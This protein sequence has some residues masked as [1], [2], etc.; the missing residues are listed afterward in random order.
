MARRIVVA[1]L[2]GGVGKSTTVLNLGQALS[3]L[4]HRVLLIDL[5]PQAG[6]TASVGID[7]YDLQRSTYSLLMKD[8]IA[9]GRVVKQLRDRL[10]LVPATEN[11]TTAEIKLARQSK[12]PDRLKL[13]LDH[14]PV[15]FDY[16]LIDTPPTL[17]TLTLNGLLA[18]NELIIPV[19][20]EYLSMRSVRAVI[21]TVEQVRKAMNPDLS[22]LGVLITLYEPEARVQREAVE[23]IRKVFGGN[24]FDTVIPDRAVVA[25][26]PIEGL[27]VLDYAPDHPAAHAYRALAQEISKRGVSA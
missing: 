13:A 10:M 6:L 11:L 19:Q 3:E 25:E 18:A 12:P 24:V 27:S 17:G 8:D 1:N 20:P 14:S 7:P 15:D 21:N 26:A 9:I 22:I 16:V 23:E 4:G 5:D 2:K